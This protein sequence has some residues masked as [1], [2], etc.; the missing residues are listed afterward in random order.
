[1][2]A[3]GADI[4]IESNAGKKSGLLDADYEAMGATIAHSAADTVRD[5]DVVFKVRRPTEVELAD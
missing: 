5:A 2:K 3:L 4:V 1:M